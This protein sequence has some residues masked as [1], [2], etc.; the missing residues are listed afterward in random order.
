MPASALYGFILAILVL[1]ASGTR[2]Q[3]PSTPTSVRQVTY[4]EFISLTVDQRRE[5]FRQMSPENKALV[6]RTHGERWL[7]DNRGRLTATE[8]AIFREVIDFVTP[9][10]YRTPMAPEV[11]RKERALRAKLRCRVDDN[12]VMRAFNVFRAPGDPPVAP[13]WTYLSRAKCWFEWLVET[14]VD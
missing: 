13:K 8:R 10:L 2:S 4:D 9:E 1:C 12:D 14:V 6:I 3:E 11:D 7:N 5:R